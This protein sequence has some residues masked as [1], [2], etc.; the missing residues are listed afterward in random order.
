M[1]SY[2]NLFCSLRYVCFDSSTTSRP[3]WTSRGS[4]G[5]NPRPSADGH[6][7]HLQSQGARATVTVICAGL[8]PT[9]F[10]YRNK[11]TWWEI[12]VW[13]K[14]GKKGGSR[15]SINGVSKTLL[16][17]NHCVVVGEQ[18]LR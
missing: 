9:A 2:R 12:Q 6:Q 17:Q 1:L 4:R 14:T 8:R 15:F 7:G 3:V 18:G 5:T 16:L 11:T 13:L 10:G